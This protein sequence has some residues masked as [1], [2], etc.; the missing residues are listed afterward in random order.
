MKL[1]KL[2]MLIGNN[3]L[4]YKCNIMHVYYLEYYNTHSIDFLQF[5]NHNKVLYSDS[6]TDAP[7]MLLL[8]INTYYLLTISIELYVLL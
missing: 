1:K 7:Y 5:Q 6:S 2:C 8:S 3:L 4:F